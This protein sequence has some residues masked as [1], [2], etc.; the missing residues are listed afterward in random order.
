MIRPPRRLL[1]HHH[2]HHIITSRTNKRVSLTFLL[3]FCWSLRRICLGIGRN[4]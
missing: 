2:Q 1:L 4:G 3:V